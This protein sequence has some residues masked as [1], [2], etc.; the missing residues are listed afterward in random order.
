MIGPTAIDDAWKCKQLWC[1]LLIE[2]RKLLP[3]R[4]ASQR[5]VLR[6]IFVAAVL[7]FM[8]NFSTRRRPLDPIGS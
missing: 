1:L 7:L 3:A 2:G 8:D 4:N 5:T 6:S